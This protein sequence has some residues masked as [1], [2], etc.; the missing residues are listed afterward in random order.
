LV[1]EMK[2]SKSRKTKTIQRIKTLNMF[3]SSNVQNVLNFW[4][5]YG[6]YIVHV[7]LFILILLF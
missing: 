2:S 1:A 6:W 3:L 7:W 4:N 5:N